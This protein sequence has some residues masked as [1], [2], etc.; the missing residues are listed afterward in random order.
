MGR[1]RSGLKASG[2]S[3][4]RRAS[5]TRTLIT[6]PA[7]DRGFER[8]EHAGAPLCSLG[9]TL[10]PRARMR[11]PTA[12]PQVLC[13]CLHRSQPG[14]WPEQ[15][16]KK[17]SRARPMTRGSTH[18]QPEGF[19]EGCIC[20]PWRW[21]GGVGDSNDSLG[22]PRTNNSARGKYLYLPP[23][24]IR[25]GSGRGARPRRWVAPSA[26]RLPRHVGTEKLTMPQQRVRERERERYA[27][28]SMSLRGY[29]TTLHPDVS[30]V[31]K[32]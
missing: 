21:Q 19:F 29:Q 6:G 16:A 3:R 1:R 15:R 4:A 11:G 25:Q 23:C 24:N 17:Q 28:I 14:A 22:P 2:L 30:R 27:S 18:P 31:G 26:G 9:A 10:L 12:E 32:K 8:A 13:S 7:L 5:T 20:N